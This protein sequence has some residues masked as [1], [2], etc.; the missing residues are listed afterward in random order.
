MVTV[1]RRT[2]ILATV[3]VVV[4][5][6]TCQIVA[7]GL[8]TGK[9]EEKRSL[10]AAIGKGF[11]RSFQNNAKSKRS[12]QGW[13]GTV[14]GG[15]IRDTEVKDEDEDDYEGKDDYDYQENSTIDDLWYEVQC[16]DLFASGSRTLDRVDLK[17]KYLS[18]VKNKQFTY[19][20]SEKSG[21]LVT[22]PTTQIQEVTLIPRWMISLDTINIW[23]VVHKVTLQCNLTM[24]QVKNL[25]PS[26]HPVLYPP[27]SCSKEVSE[28]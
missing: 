16:G 24:H 19:M 5:L 1:T 17:E 7:G 10:P 8:F 20:L 2:A 14:G 13:G 4:P 23:Q 15:G 28:W 18:R 11:K 22:S 27:P 25:I 12:H 9:R 26:I 3:A 6:L 21:I